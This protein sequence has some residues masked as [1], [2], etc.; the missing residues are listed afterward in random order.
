MVAWLIIA[1][2][3][4]VFG[5]G[6]AEAGPG[7]CSPL[8]SDNPDTGCA[9]IPAAIAA[10]TA[11]AEAAT[12]NGYPDAVVC[13]T[14]VVES[15]NF[16]RVS[17]CAFQ[18]GSIF[19]SQ[20]RYYLTNCSTPGTVYDPA[21]MTC[22]Q[23]C[24][25]KPD[26][27]SSCPAGLCGAYSTFRSGTVSCRGGCTV[28]WFGNGDGTYTGKY[29][30]YSNTCQEP[31]RCDPALL[32]AGYVYN[33]Y[34]NACVPPPAECEG[35]ETRDPASGECRPSCPEGQSLDEFG[36]CKPQKNTCPPGEVKSPE[37]NCLPGDGQCAAGE[38]RRAD[39]TCGK[40]E[41]GDGEADD[42]DDNPDND[43]D[44]NSFSGG[45]NCNTPPSCSG[46]PIM[47]GQARIQWRIDCNTRRNRDVSGGTCG[48]VPI[49]TGDKCDALEYASLLQQWRT[50]C[51]LQELL[52]REGGTGDGGQPGWTKVDGMSQDPGQGAT[53]DDAPGLTT[54]ALTTDDLDQSGLGG[55]GSCA[56]IM[57]ASGGQLSGG[58]AS[59]LA[60]PPPMFC[61]WIN[62]IKAIV[63]LVAAVTSCYI[64]AKGG[65]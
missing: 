41:D 14:E 29:D 32:A 28:S 7:T 64:L 33:A 45:D 59:F 35:N 43:S 2:L 58:F 3:A 44:K 26:E 51:S 36:Q 60:S 1:A 9:D 46:D 4:A 42:E 56:A 16:A 49:C 19:H 17:K 52:A 50:A 48:A 61:N 39:G 22:R 65:R 31:Y 57:T 20:I 18:G 24:A 21:T 25:S 63:V 54:V 12:H 55:G 23:D 6:R 34:A 40:D 5:T 10:A 13:K 15:S 53:P 37:G 27:T 11:A 38:A 8:P 62:M 47:C 30:V